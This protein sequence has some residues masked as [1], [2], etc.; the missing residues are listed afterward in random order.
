MFRAM[1]SSNVSSKGGTCHKKP[2][3]GVPLAAASKALHALDESKQLAELL[4]LSSAHNLLLSSKNFLTASASTTR[5]KHE[6]LRSLA[7]DSF[8][9]NHPD[10]E[11]LVNKKFVEVDMLVRPELELMFEKVG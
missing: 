5:N 1:P 7:S 8:F 2:R 11:Q 9:S 3:D 4:D 6:H 10:M